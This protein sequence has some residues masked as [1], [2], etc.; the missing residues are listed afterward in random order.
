MKA[1]SLQLGQITLQFP[2][3][4]GETGWLQTASTA[5]LTDCYSTIVCLSST[6]EFAAETRAVFGSADS[7]LSDR[8][9]SAPNSVALRQE[10]LLGGI[11]GS[12]FEQM[13]IVEP[14]WKT[15]GTAVRRAADA[16]GRT[17]RAWKPSSFRWSLQSTG[18]SSARRISFLAVS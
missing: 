13:R 14:H 11:W 2:K 7:V 6:A 17:Y 18:I 15:P 16:K 5:R 1:F 8:D 4:Q 9:T 3:L 12:T 10:S